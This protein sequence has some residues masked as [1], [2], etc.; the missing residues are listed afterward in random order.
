ME[1]HTSNNCIATI[2]LKQVEDPTRY[3]VVK[4]G[5]ENIIQKFV[6][7]PTLE[8]APSNWIN[9][10]CYALN[11]KILEKIPE[12]KVSI[13]REVFPKIAK[14]GELKGYK[15]KG[16]WIDIGLPKDYLHADKMIRET[17]NSIN[18]SSI[19]HPN[20][21]I[22]NTIIWEHTTIHRYTII[23]D[24]IIGTNTNIGPVSYTHL[25]AHET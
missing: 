17:E 10:G 15:Y 2:T 18:Q 23:K 24:T 19:I 16:D 8:Q 25:R 21:N 9:A 14:K 22:K 6:E 12:G 20:T 11:P 7:K 3:G 1:K 4:F 5:E 13:E